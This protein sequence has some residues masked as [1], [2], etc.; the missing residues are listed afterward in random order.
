VRAVD[1]ESLKAPCAGTAAGAV[2]TGA[3][4]FD[5]WAMRDKHP[6]VPPPQISRRAM[7]HEVQLD[8]PSCLYNTTSVAIEPGS[9]PATQ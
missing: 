1:G 5:R 8:T 3:W 9:E 2:C 4:C 7:D 6:T